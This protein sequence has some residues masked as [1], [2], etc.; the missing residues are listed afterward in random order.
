MYPKYMCYDT[1]SAHFHV[2]DIFDF[3]I[4]NY[5]LLKQIWIFRHFE[6]CF[7]IYHYV[8]LWWCVF[9]IISILHIRWVT[10]FLVPYKWKAFVLLFLSGK[11]LSYPYLKVFS[12]G[13][14]WQVTYL[15]NVF[16]SRGYFMDYGV[17]IEIIAVTCSM[18]ATQCRIS[19]WIC[20]VNGKEIT[21]FRV[22]VI[23]NLIQKKRIHSPLCPSSNNRC[24]TTFSNCH[25]YYCMPNLHHSHPF[26]F[27]THLAIL[28][29]CYCVDRAYYYCAPFYFHWFRLFYYCL[30][31]YY[32]NYER[33]NHRPILV[34]I[35]VA[36][37][38]LL[39]LEFL[40]LTTLLELCS[41]IVVLLTY[42][43]LFL[44]ELLSE[45]ENKIKIN[46]F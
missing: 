43:L 21:N 36:V 24:S 14:W 16:S 30:L 26:D 10:R 2:F 22:P 28:Y 18:I 4:C 46:F 42:L 37:C 34:M 13:K 39:K 6:K 27:P 1:P 32:L 12:N 9:A 25:Y 31:I 3:A 8:Y 41:M 44:P 38:R 23:L 29:Y 33:Y 17:N 40:A 20:V 11:L 35:G 7:K 5:L 15:R 19:F 45:N